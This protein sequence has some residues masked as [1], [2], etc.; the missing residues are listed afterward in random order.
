MGEK[1]MRRFLVLCA[2]VAGLG[3]SSH[4]GVQ[5]LYESYGPEQ[6]AN[7][8]AVAVNTNAKANG[9]REDSTNV[10]D[11]VKR[12]AASLWSADK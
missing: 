12:A 9:D 6:Y 5:L 3:F 8:S 11:Y 10:F 4:Y 2:V 7:A 1:Q